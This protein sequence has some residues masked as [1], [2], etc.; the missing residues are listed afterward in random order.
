[1]DDPIPAGFITLPEALR[2]IANHVSEA[3]LEYTK[4]DL[5]ERLRA[6]R[7]IRQME[8]QD[9]TEPNESAPAETADSESFQPPLEKQG[10]IETN[11]PG[12]V[13]PADCKV[14]ERPSEQSWR[15]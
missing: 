6:L 3:Q 14:F 5:Q 4:I 13:E 8:K 15:Q 7:A 10:A 11:E 12:F 9:A 2:R 1:M